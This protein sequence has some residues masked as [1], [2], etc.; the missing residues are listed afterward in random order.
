[1]GRRECRQGS[2]SARSA[3]SSSAPASH[4]GVIDPGELIEPGSL[5]PGVEHGWCSLPEDARLVR[6]HL[7]MV[8]NRCSVARMPG[9]AGERHYRPAMTVHTEIH[10]SVLVVTIDRPERG[11]RSTGRPRPNCSRPSPPSRRTIRCR[12]RSSPE[13]TARSVQARPQGD[14]DRERQ[15]DRP[16]R[17]RSDGPDPPGPLEAGH[18]CGGGLRRRRRTELAVWCDLRVAAEDATFGVYCR[19]WVCPLLTAARS[20]CPGSSVRR[21]PTT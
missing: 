12:W 18:R 8:A 4:V 3:S 14:L 9:T 10:D 1:M 11:M 13:R 15:P 17:S 7:H 6:Q 2:A 5:D 16:H 19:R 21:S 20:A